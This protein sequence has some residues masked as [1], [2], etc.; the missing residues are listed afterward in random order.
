M[1]LLMLSTT[2]PC[3]AC[4][5]IQTRALCGAYN[6]RCVRCCARLVMSARPNRKAQEGML[7]C[8]T[9]RPE[10]PAQA[11]ILQAI[12]EADG[13]APPPPAAKVSRGLV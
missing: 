6:L 2:Q 9:R 3:P 7:A 4:T 8:I 13:A 5:L 10:N 12:K 11:E 1:A